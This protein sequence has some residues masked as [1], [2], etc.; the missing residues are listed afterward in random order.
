MPSGQDDWA[1][2]AKRMLKAELKRADVTYDDLAKRLT[3]MGL[4]ES[5]ASV[6]MKINRGAFPTW[7]FMAS[8]KAIGK[9]SVTL[10]DP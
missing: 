7:F 10:D 9:P 5:Q 6:T 8:M 3:T 2:K 1:E 4:P